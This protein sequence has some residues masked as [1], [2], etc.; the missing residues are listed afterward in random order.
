MIS[1]RIGDDT[2]LE[3]Y[4]TIWTKIRDLK[5]I[6]LNA[7]PVYND[8]YIKAKIR[9]YG[10]K[11]YTNSSVL[12]VPKDSVPRRMWIFYNHLYWFFACLWEQVLSTSIFRQLYL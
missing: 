5:N 7:L 4:E 3:K 12:N 2:L 10:D 9:T 11:V 6:E 8:R 1:F